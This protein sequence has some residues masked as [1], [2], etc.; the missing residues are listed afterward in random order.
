M[1]FAGWI[2]NIERYCDNMTGSLAKL[3]YV[4]L[5]SLTLTFY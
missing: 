3:K 1:M 4:D 2:V 5:P